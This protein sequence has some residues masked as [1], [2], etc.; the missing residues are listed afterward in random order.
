MTGRKETELYGP[1][2]AF[3]VEQ[4]YTVRGE[5]NGCDLVAVRDE[6]L[7]I[8][9]LKTAF[10]LPLLLQG[11]ERQRLT[12]LVYLAIEA[13]GRALGR[14]RWNQ[15]V[16][17]CRRLGLGLLTVRFS[18]HDARVE[19]ICDP[20]A[21]TP[22]RNAKKK[23]QLL[24]EFQRRTLD[25][26]TGGSTRRP[27]VTA[28]REEALRIAAYLVQ[29]GPTKLAQ[30]RVAADSPRASSILQDDYYG[31]FERVRIGVYQL[32]PKGAAALTTYADVV[33]AA[34]DPPGDES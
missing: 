16:Q 33:A 27:L 31:W 13:P 34:A 2:K 4:G 21:Y 19:A 23:G 3:L 14:K 10:N 12:D 28:Y 8:V 22:P 30:L 20:G 1:V 5:V 18:T 24:K 26:N 32:T 7:V 25:H 15:V 6:L 29:N 17:L 9:E 11:V